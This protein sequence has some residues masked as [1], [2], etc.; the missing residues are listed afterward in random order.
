MRRSQ[1]ITNVPYVDYYGNE[2][3][4]EEYFRPT[5]KIPT[6]NVFEELV[7]DSFKPARVQVRRSQSTL[8]CG[9]V[10]I[11]DREPQVFRPSAPYARLDP[12]LV[13][14]ASPAAVREIFTRQ[15]SLYGNRRYYSRFSLGNTGYYDYDLKHA[16]DAHRGWKVAQFGP[17]NPSAWENKYL[18]NVSRTQGFKMASPNMFI[19]RDQYP[20]WRD[21]ATS[22]LAGA[23]R[24]EDY[25]KTRFTNAREPY[26]ASR[27]YLPRSVGL[28]EYLPRSMGLPYISSYY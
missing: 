7:K 1:S 8:D 9:A 24:S 4:D 10:F 13:K 27:Q 5:K 2:L 17:T 25:W 11:P 28:P 23:L 18:T 6:K 3:M 15:N 16:I 14:H 20:T 19:R 22:A 26:Y 21:T 12:L